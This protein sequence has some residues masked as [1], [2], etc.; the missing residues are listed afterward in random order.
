[1]KIQ[2]RQNRRGT[3]LFLVNAQATPLYFLP[4]EN[5]ASGL[6]FPLPH[7]GHPPL[8]GPHFRSEN[9]DDST[10]DNGRTRGRLLYRRPSSKTMFS[11]LFRTP[12][13][14]TGLSVRV[15]RLTLLFTAF[16]HIS[17]IIATKQGI[18]QQER[19]K[20]FHHSGKSAIYFPGFRSNPT[21]PCQF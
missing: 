17:N 7:K 13:H 9:T 8:R 16:F 4:A 15:S 12:F 5:S 1:M 2:G 6:A 20:S 18:C 19:Q 21:D 10:R 14:Q 3:T 11:R